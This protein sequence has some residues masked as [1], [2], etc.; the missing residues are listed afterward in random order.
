M[1]GGA[2]LRCGRCWWLLHCLLLLLLRLLLL[3]GH[4]CNVGLLPAVAATASS[5]WATRLALRTAA[6][7]V[8]IDHQRGIGRAILVEDHAGLVAILAQM[9]LEAVAVLGGVVAVGTAVLVDGAVGL[10]MRVEHGLVDA[11]V[12]ALVALEGLLV[13]VLADVVLQVVLEL[14]DERALGALQDLVRLHVGAGVR[15]EVHLGDGHHAARLAL[16]VLHLSVRIVDGHANV[17]VVVL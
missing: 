11:G 10:A 9:E 16:V 2:E 12:A 8:D 14:G 1:Q 3:R 15:P 17:G 4:S 13:L 6:R 7:A 5:R